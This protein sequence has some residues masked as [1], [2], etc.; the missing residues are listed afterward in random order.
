MTWPLNCLESEQQ[1]L[2]KIRLNKS[3]SLP[4]LDDSNFLAFL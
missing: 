4:R 3:S 1:L 2:E